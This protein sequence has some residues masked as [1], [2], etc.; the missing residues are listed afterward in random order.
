MVRMD[1][2]TTVVSK[3]DKVSSGVLALFVRFVGPIGYLN[4][5]STL[6]GGPLV[7]LWRGCRVHLHLKK[8]KNYQ[9]LLCLHKITA[10]SATSS[11]TIYS[12]ISDTH[13]YSLLL[14][15]C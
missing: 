1:S 13:T 15:G 4:S 5:G 3:S 9:C 6:G 11:I 7:V 2:N 10:V 8:K 12:R 14:G